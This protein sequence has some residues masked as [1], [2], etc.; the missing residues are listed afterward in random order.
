M[1]VLKCDVRCLWIRWKDSSLIGDCFHFRR[2][3]SANWRMLTGWFDFFKF[4]VTGLRAS[5]LIFPPKSILLHA[6]SGDQYSFAV[7]GNFCRVSATIEDFFRICVINTDGGPTMGRA[8]MYDCYCLW[9]SGS[10]QLNWIEPSTVAP[11]HCT[12]CRSALKWTDFAYLP[13]WLRWT[14][15]TYV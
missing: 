15:S 11:R 3:I 2:S 7:G 6:R 14:Y 10:E 9:L 12:Y 1:K 4:T 13:S 5:T 8:R